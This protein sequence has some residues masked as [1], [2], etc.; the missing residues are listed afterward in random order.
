MH[1]PSAAAKGRERGPSVLERRAVEEA[2]ANRAAQLKRQ[3]ARPPM[4]MDETPDRQ[5]GSRAGFAPVSA[6]G[7]SSHLH[8][9]AA[10][11]RLGVRSAHGARSAASG[12]AAMEPGEHLMMHGLKKQKLIE[13]ARSRSVHAVLGCA[14][15]GTADIGSAPRLADFASDGRTNEEA[16]QMHALAMRDWMAVNMSKRGLQEATAVRAPLAHVP[17]PGKALTDWPH[18]GVSVCVRA[19]TRYLNRLSILSAWAEESGVGALVEWVQTSEG[20]WE[21]KKVLDTDGKPRAPTPEMLVCFFIEMASGDGLVQKGGSPAHRQHPRN[22]PIFG[23]YDQGAWMVDENRKEFGW[24]AYADE[25]FAFVTVEQYCSAFAWFYDEVVLKGAREEEVNPA[26]SLRVRAVKETLAKFLGRGVVHQTPALLQV[27]VQK[28]LGEAD[29]SNVD[30][31]GIALGLA[32][33]L[34][35]GARAKA[36]WMLDWTD[37]ELKFESSPGE[38]AGVVLTYLADKDDR[39]QLYSSWVARSRC[40]A[41]PPVPVACSSNKTGV[42]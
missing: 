21:A 1:S 34:V 23:R 32:V 6:C 3:L 25:P 28:M 37:V 41:Q 39:Q 42:H 24:G 12:L 14:P 10:A 17:A 22:R 26:R 38:R 36:Q 13:K 19:Q 33:G 16:V 2:A 8:S 20:M 4:A 15:V 5:G 18:A 35:I 27:H 40:R 9:H 11:D 7:T 30:E 29:W 31:V